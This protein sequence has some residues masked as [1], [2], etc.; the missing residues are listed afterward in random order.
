MFL[1][2]KVWFRLCWGL[3]GGVPPHEHPWNFTKIADE[4]TLSALNHGLHFL[5]L[6]CFV[7]LETCNLQELLG[8]RQVH[9]LRYGPSSRTSSSSSSL[10]LTRTHGRCWCF[11]SVGTL[12]PDICRTSNP[13]IFAFAL[14]Y[15]LT[16]WFIHRCHWTLVS[17][18]QISPF[19]LFLHLS[20]RLFEQTNT[21]EGPRRARQRDVRL[22]ALV[23]P[24]WEK[25]FLRATQRSGAQC[26][27]HKTNI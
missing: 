9:H 2:V 8:G 4:E 1:L 18:L 19:S 15:F 6:C 7:L 17:I 24:V 11:L 25:V 26:R 21:H 12:I 5:A 27:A 23:A 10:C 16:I 14:F 3:G 22:F 13:K 20:W